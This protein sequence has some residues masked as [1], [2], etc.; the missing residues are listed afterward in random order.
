MV[1]LSFLCLFSFTATSPLP[2]PAPTLNA[3]THNTPLHPIHG[4]A[5]HYNATNAPNKHV[6]VGWGEYNC[7]KEETHP[8]ASDQLALNTTDQAERHM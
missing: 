3:H 6:C 4:H 2:P 7:V 8:P 5:P 1:H